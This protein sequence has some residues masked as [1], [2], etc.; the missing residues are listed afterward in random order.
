M[1]AVK[2]SVSVAGTGSPI[3]NAPLSYTL[4][5]VNQDANDYP[6]YTTVKGLST[7][8]WAGSAQL[9]FSDIDSESQSYALI[10]YS[11]LNGLKGMGYYVNIPPAL[12]KTVIPLIDSFQNRIILLT[13][14]DSV[15]QPP[16]PPGYSQLNYNASFVILS[17]DYSLREFSL[18][19]AKLRL[20]A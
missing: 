9:V 19:P 20:E 15:G 6:S 2:L 10:I 5:L 16:Q 4:M 7:T 12:T 8:D 14:S 13:H 18:E 3:A 1:V 17:E 11:Y